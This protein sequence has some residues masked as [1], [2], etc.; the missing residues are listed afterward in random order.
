[1]LLGIVFKLTRKIKMIQP[2]K[3]WKNFQDM[4]TASTKAQRHQRVWGSP[5]W[6]KGEADIS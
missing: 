1:M 5:G 2:A 6:L 4:G 3:T